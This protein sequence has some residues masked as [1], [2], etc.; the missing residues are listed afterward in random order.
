MS[1]VD[2]IVGLMRGRSCRAGSQLALALLT[3]ALLAAGVAGCAATLA[4]DRVIEAYDTTTT[5]SVAQQLLLNIARARHNQPMHFTGISSVAATYKMSSRCTSSTS[6]QFLALS[7]SC[8]FEAKSENRISENQW[9]ARLNF[10][11]FGNLRQS[12]NYTYSDVVGEFMKPYSCIRATLRN[13]LFWAMQNNSPTTSTP[14]IPQ[15]DRGHKSACYLGATQPTLGDATMKRRHFLRVGAAMAGSM[16]GLLAL[17]GQSEAVA[18]SE[19]VAAAGGSAGS[20][21]L[22]L[23]PSSPQFRGLTQGFNRRWT[24]PN[25]AVVLVPLTEAGAEAALTHVLA[26]G[27]GEH[28]RVRGGGHCYEDFVYNAETQALIDVSLLNRIG[29][30]EKDG[31]YFAQAGGTNWDLY[32]HLYW[33]FGK[34]LPAGSCYSVGLG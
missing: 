14:N 6:G 8:L 13:Q 31:V 27:Y 29:Y 19:F 28:F 12:Q 26:D 33:Q 7:Q 32:R 3:V 9:L 21:L 4:L 22:I 18:K 11:V 2:V 10:P 24:A 20:D 30:D 34:T 25:V 23:H 16:A 17:T 15:A 1:M 5:D